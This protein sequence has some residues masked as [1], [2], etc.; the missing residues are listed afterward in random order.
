VLLEPALPSVVEFPELAAPADP[1]SGPTAE[2]R[3]TDNFALNDEI[4]LDVGEILALLEES[5]SLAPPL[6][7]ALAGDPGK[8]A[9]LEGLELAPAAPLAEQILRCESPASTTTTSLAASPSPLRAFSRFSVEEWCPEA[10]VAAEAPAARSWLK[11]L[12][13]LTRLTTKR[14]ANN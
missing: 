10:P 11:R 6:P 5:D 2:P 1:A 9:S 14:R 8:G 7:A 4:S 3:P 12:P 13:K